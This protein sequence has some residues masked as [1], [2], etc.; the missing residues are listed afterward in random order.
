MTLQICILTISVL[1][2][3]N[4]NF[5]TVYSVQLRD[6]VIRRADMLTFT[7]SKQSLRK[8]KTD[9]VK[10]RFDILYQI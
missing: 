2:Q 5:V 9:N 10:N 7:L 4:S 1:R 3:Q 6:A 8:G